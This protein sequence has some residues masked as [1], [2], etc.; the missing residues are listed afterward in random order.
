[1]TS[2][3][4][5]TGQSSAL[6]VL[7][8]EL[9]LHVCDRLGLPDHKKLL[10][11]CRYLAFALQA[12]LFQRV[13][14]RGAPV[15]YPAIAYGCKQ[16]NNDVIRRSLLSG[17]PSQVD[18]E[19][20]PGMN[21]LGMASLYGN[22]SGVAYLLQH[23]ADVNK[24]IPY[25]YSALA[26]ALVSLNTRIHPRDCYPHSMETI[27]SLLDAGADPHCSLPARFLGYHKLG[28]AI[29][30]VV[31][32]FEYSGRLSMTHARRLVERLV[33]E[34][35][36]PD[37]L[38]CAES[39]LQ[40]AVG[41]FEKHPG[42]LRFLLDK[43]ADPNFGA[44]IT[45]KYTALTE[46]ILTDNIEAME[47]LIS[48]G[49]DPCLDTRGGC[50][51]LWYAVTGNQYPIVISLLQHGVNP[52]FVDTGHTAVYE[53]GETV[54]T[55]LSA[56]IYHQAPSRMS[57]PMIEH[58][59][60]FGADPNIRDRDDCT[61][62]FC[63]LQGP[64]ALSSSISGLLLRHGADPNERCRN[65]EWTPLIS[66]I[67]PHMYGT[68]GHK[69]LFP[70]SPAHRLRLA[71]LL[72]EAGADINL[73]A[74]IRG[75]SL[76]PLEAAL[77]MPRLELSAEDECQFVC[78]AALD[79]YKL[80]MLWA[81]RAAEM[82]LHSSPRDCLTMERVPLDGW[83]DALIPILLRAGARVDGVLLHRLGTYMKRQAPAYFYP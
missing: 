34:G 9:L 49:A 30:A 41:N 59:L 24:V 8:R 4:V 28:N 18:G 11:T 44:N 35:V 17:C 60:Q 54:S 22:S 71:K 58:L 55:A 33:H 12:Y 72:L 20:A 62:L 65:G 32:A 53:Y 25:G 50:S 37:G 46:A 23:R 68:A 78:G 7:L 67:V 47:L 45:S 43:G 52:N 36:S 79:F 63:A 73:L 29:T 10:K 83:E 42:L 74:T 2:L 76:S 77:K 16:F 61:S 81:Q 48:R 64:S 75:I 51:Y 66:A 38:G 1:M 56:A 27:L 80:H 31:D 69:G 13:S 14:I 21:A 57:M 6:V 15:H 26:Y 5:S 3:F 39:P 82:G 40:W 19:A 70:V